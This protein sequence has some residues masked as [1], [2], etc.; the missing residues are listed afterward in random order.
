MRHNLVPW[1]T[2]LEGW[3]LSRKC[4]CCLF[5]NQ[6]KLGLQI[7]LLHASTNCLK[8]L[9]LQTLDF[10]AMPVKG[11]PFSVLVEC[12][13]KLGMN[14]FA[15]N[16]KT[17]TVIWAFIS[18]VHQLLCQVQCLIPFPNSVFSVTDEK[19]TK[20]AKKIQDRAEVRKPWFSWMIIV[21][22][23]GQLVKF[24]CCFFDAFSFSFWFRHFAGNLFHLRI[25]IV[26]LLLLYLLPSH[27]VKRNWYQTVFS[28][29][30]SVCVLNFVS[31]VRSSRIVLQILKM[32]F[33]LGTAE[34]GD[35]AGLFFG[36]WM[37]LLNC[38]RYC[39]WVTFLLTWRLCSNTIWDI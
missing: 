2:L 6:I 15:N 11:I 25:S 37:Q 33:S 3:M 13:F 7:A 5:L 1:W 35:V 23:N 21:C 18:C 4:I 38:W 39:F 14:C 34:F 36:I 22:R 28:V 12:T 20:I 30:A 8:T 16:N 17:V 9:D 19:E 24:P 26:Q 27:D 32:W 31:S 10:I 29:I